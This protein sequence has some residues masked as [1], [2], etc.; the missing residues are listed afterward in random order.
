MDL[1]D[2]PDT[3][4]DSVTKPELQID[5]SRITHPGV[6][7][8]IRSTLQDIIGKA[9]D[10]QNKMRKLQKSYLELREVYD[11]TGILG[12][13][14]RSTHISKVL[15]LLKG[16]DQS[17]REYQEAAEQYKAN[18]AQLLVIARSAYVD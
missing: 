9:H 8:E 2:N 3:W 12:H 1:F 5:F 7:D 18:F 15:P 11:A 13:T 17:R 10:V 14:E 6:E 4:S 16:M